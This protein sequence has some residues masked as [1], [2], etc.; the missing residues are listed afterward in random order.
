MKDKNY[1]N[2]KREESKLPTKWLWFY[3]KIRLPLAV[4][5]NVIILV[6]Y[7]STI[8]LS[9]FDEIGLTLVIGEIIF[10]LGIIVLQFFTA[11][12]MRLLTKRSYKLNIFLLSLEEIYYL[13][14]FVVLNYY[15]VE[16][17]E[18][19]TKFITYGIFVLLNFVYFKNRKNLFNE[20]DI[21]IKEKVLEVENN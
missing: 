3:T 1:F 17:S 19:L 2:L 5:L 15:A 11:I 20:E 10:I 8:D 9:Q 16:S 12:E 4:I 18:A 14:V 13:Y 21:V 7:L 6:N